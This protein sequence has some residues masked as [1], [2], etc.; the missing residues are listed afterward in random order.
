MLIA[1]IT[2]RHFLTINLFILIIQGHQ[3]HLLPLKVKGKGE[4][5]TGVLSGIYHVSLLMSFLLD[6]DR[7]PRNPGTIYNKVT[8][9]DKSKLGPL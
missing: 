4:P 9:D 3:P 1:N 6:V 5:Q 7:L 2:S 8:S